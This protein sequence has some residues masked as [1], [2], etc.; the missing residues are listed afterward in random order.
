MSFIENARYYRIGK[1]VWR[2]EK[3]GDLE[4]CGCKSLIGA[5]LT[6]RQLIQTQGGKKGD[7]RKYV[8]YVAKS[9]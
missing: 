8:N 2:R 1:A 5:A 4:V 9:S 6:V 3:N 7:W